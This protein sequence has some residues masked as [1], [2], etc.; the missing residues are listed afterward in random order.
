MSGCVVAEAFWLV[1][2]MPIL[3]RNEL[4]SELFHEE[5]VLCSLGCSKI[6]WTVLPNESMMMAREFSHNADQCQTSTKY[7]Y[8]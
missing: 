6:L 3:K 4:Q 5:V 7:Y 8:Y 2:I 1:H